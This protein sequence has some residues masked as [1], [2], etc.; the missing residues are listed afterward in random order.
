MCGIVYLYV[1]W[2]WAESVER[3]REG[4][5]RQ[6]GRRLVRTHLHWCL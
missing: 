4:E 5:G 1:Y 6:L 2:F 3:V